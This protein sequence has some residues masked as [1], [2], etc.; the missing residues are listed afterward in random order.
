MPFVDAEAISTGQYQQDMAKA[1][2]AQ[3]HL[4]L[5]CS[6]QQQ[7]TL[8][9]QSIKPNDIA[10][11]VRSGRE[12]HIMQQA[13]DACGIASVYL[14]NRESVFAQPIAHRITSYNVCYT[15]LLRMFI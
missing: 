12:A 11:L 14:S 7:A 15:K 8:D 10:V 4:W 9:G 3:I 2:A 6:Q 13:L 1:A 5:V